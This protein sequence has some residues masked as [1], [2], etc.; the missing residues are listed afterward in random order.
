MALIKCYV[1]GQ[2]RDIDES[3][4]EAYRVEVDNENEHTIVTGWKLNGVVVQNDVNMVLKQGS[5]VADAMAASL[6]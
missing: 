4:L 2:M 1:D 3:E 5:V 6:G